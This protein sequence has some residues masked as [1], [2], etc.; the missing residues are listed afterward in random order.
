MKDF[1]FWTSYDKYVIEAT[2]FYKHFIL[3]PIY[4]SNKSFQGF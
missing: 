4:K 1:G 2:S 3:V